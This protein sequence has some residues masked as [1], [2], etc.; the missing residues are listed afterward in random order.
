MD[1][2]AE[3]IGDNGSIEDYLKIASY[4]HKSNSHFKTGVFYLKGQEYSKVSIGFIT[5]AMKMLCLLH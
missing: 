3:V 1:E 2:Y 4:Y 5:I